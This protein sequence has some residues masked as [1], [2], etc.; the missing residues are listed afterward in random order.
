MQ[1]KC[2]GTEISSAASV[3]IWKCS[4]NNMEHH[5]S[6]DSFPLDYFH[7]SSVV[8]S[9]QATLSE[10]ETRNGSLSRHSHSSTPVAW[11]VHLASVN[12]FSL[13]DLWP[14]SWL[15][16]FQNGFFKTKHSLFQQSTHAEQRVKNNI[17][18]F[19]YSLPPSK[20]IFLEAL[21]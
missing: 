1:N 4:R 6:W 11:Q 21:I 18:F 20:Q 5:C 8:V 10:D 14:L 12:P 2:L 17:T 13:R 3:T 15:M 7:L 9:D 16:V 19:G